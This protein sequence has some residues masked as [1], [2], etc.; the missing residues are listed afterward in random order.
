M[1]NFTVVGNEQLSELLNAIGLLTQIGWFFLVGLA[2]LE[3]TPKNLKLNG[4][5]FKINGILI[6]VTGVIALIFFD[7]EIQPTGPLG[8]I[9]ICYCMFAIFHFFSY[10]AK[11]LKSIETNKEAKLWNYLGYFALM[12]FWVIGIWGIQMKL[13]HVEKHGL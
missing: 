10:P 8:F 6:L 4:T 1:M 7:G 2:L 5:L 13:N 3:R 12:I 9:W 11:L